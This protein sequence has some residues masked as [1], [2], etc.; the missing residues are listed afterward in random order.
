MG[1]KDSAKK[2]IG[3]VANKVLKNLKNINTATF[4]D[5]STKENREK[6][7]EYDYSYALTKRAE[8]EVVWK[9]ND[10]YYNNV[11]EVSDELANY[12]KDQ[13]IPWSPAIVPDSYIHIESQIIPDLPD[14]EF[15]GRDD[16][17]DSK[18][19]KQREYVV[20][21]VLENNK[22]ENMNTTNERRLGITGNAFWKV[23]WDGNKSGY[24]Y[25]GDIVIGNPACENI[26]PEPV[27]L[28]IDDGESFIY[29]YRQHKR[30][31]SREFLSDLKRLDKTI[32]ELG[33]DGKQE[34]TIIYDSQVRDGN[35]DTVQIVEYWFRQNEYGSETIDGIKYDYEPSDI[36][37][38]IQ[39]NGTELRYIPKYWQKTGKQCKMYPFVKYCKIPSITGFWDK[40][41]IEMIKD[42]QDQVDR[43]LAVAILN[44]TFMS[45]D[46][47]V[48]EEH[49]VADDTQLENRPGAIWRMKS[50]MINAVRRLGGLGNPTNRIEMI[51]FLRGIIQETVGNFDSTMGKE[52]IRVTTAS[53]IA[54]LNE[55]ADARRVIKKADRVT[56]FE[57]LY[58]LIDWTALEFYDDNRMIFI[59]AK[60]ENEEPVAF[61]YNSDNMTMRDKTGDIYY[62]RLDAIVRAGDG[63]RKSKA[64]TLAATENLINKPI[65]ETNYKIVSEMLNIMDLPNGKDIRD[66]LEQTFA[67]RLELMQLQTQQQIDQ[68]MNPPIPQPM[69]Q[70][71][72]QLQQ[73]EPSMEEILAG[74]SEKELA[75]LNENPELYE[76]V[77]AGGGNFEETI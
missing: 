6:T 27:S 10:R 24:G 13:G 42:L 63:T 35:D 67:P 9:R 72:Q 55:R 1:F 40:S 43:E 57:R 54:Q 68:I 3:T 33:T 52:P 29:A 15:K 69:P 39:I 61:E 48:A 36:A 30:A 75:T 23:S 51:N 38:S 50:G 4:W 28:D 58:E 59:G 34:D 73:Q 2:I 60:N 31:A 12:C 45:N 53:G 76:Q 41:D 25:K 8:R 5:M 17:Q 32:Y 65:N 70:Q 77:M 56:G 44:D 16:D 21:Y 20:K 18:R 46:I 62:P 26:L 71:P 11:H 74:L 19:A 49:A 22:I 37:C 14:F 64:F 66:S 47:I 7:V